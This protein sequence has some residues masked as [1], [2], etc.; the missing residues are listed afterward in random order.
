MI[1]HY[2]IKVPPTGGDRNGTHESVKRESEEIGKAIEGEDAASLT[3]L[4]NKELQKEEGSEK[5]PAVTVAEISKPK[6]RVVEDEGGGGGGAGSI[7]GLC[8]V[9]LLV[10]A[11][12]CGGAVGAFLW[13]RSKGQAPAAPDEE[14]LVHAKPEEGEAAPVEEHMPEATA[15]PE[16]KVDERTPSKTVGSSPAPS[17]QGGKSQPPEASPS[18][19]HAGG[20]WACEAADCG[21][22]E[23]AADSVECVVCGA[24]RPGH[25]PQQTPAASPA[26]SPAK[27]GLMKRP[28]QASPARSPPA[29]SPASSKAAASLAASPGAAG[30]GLT[31]D[32][33]EKV[34]QLVEMGFSRDACIDALNANGWDFESAMMSLLAG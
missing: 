18:V 10:V 24:P 3:D 16:R 27:S 22:N 31:A 33:D 8:I 21:F 15:S 12:V 11:V 4:L 30:G 13:K 2:T 32:Q 34:G 23:N 1:V 7:I 17:T 28:P 25:G 19:G 9:A 20:F 5:A 6:T 14:P 29:A 26:P